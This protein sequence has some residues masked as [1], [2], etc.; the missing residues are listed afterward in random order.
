MTRLIAPP[1]S[2]Y[3]RKVLFAAEVLDGVTMERVSRG[4]D[5]S[6]SA[7][8]G[9]PVVNASGIFVWLD[10]GVALAPQ[11]IT[12]STGLL[13]YLGTSAPS[14]LP[15]QRLVQIQL[16]PG[17]GYNFQAGVTALRFTLIES[18]AGAP[19]AAAD[20]EV[21]LRWFDAGAAVPWTDAPLRSRTDARGEASVTLRF[22]RDDEP[23]KA[24]GGALRARVCAQRGGAVTMSVEIGLAEGRVTDH[25]TAFALNQFLP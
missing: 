17:R 4:L 2:A 15:P 3:Q 1:E 8:R 25:P 12:V 16:A 24:A 5:V 23:A 13:P 20:T 7:M 14:P 22:G 19:V 18:D 21:F 10:E 11:Q 6:A 9:T